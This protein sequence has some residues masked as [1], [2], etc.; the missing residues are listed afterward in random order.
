VPV[1]PSRLHVTAGDSPR[2]GLLPF[3]S[4]PRRSRTAWHVI[5][6][7]AMVLVSGCSGRQARP[8]NRD[9]IAYDRLRVDTLFIA[10][11]GRRVVQPMNKD[12]TVVVDAAAGVLAWPAWQCNNPECPGRQADGGPYLFPWPNPFISV[13]ADGTLV[14]RQPNMPADRTLFDEFATQSCPVCKERRNLSAESPQQRQQYKDWC[15]LHE[16][17]SAAK[18]RKE[19]DQELQRITAGGKLPK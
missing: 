9:D 19:L 10:K 3:L 16:L 14:T 11:D 6:V 12:G 7:V 4:C 18:R 2:R 17:P 8:R 5:A 15:Q 13:N 1:I